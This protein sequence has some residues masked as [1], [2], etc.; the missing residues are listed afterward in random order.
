MLHFSKTC[1]V[2]KN[3]SWH[4]KDIRAMLRSLSAVCAPLISNDVAGE[5]IP[6]IAADTEIMNTIRVLMKFS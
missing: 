6:E 2:L 1:D 5:T 4:G 3:G